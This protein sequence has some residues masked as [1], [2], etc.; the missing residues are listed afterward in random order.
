MFTNFTNIQ[1]Q[2]CPLEFI[3]S[4]ILLPII[5]HNTDRQPYKLIRL[6]LHHKQHNCDQDLMRY[7]LSWAYKKLKTMNSDLWHVTLKQNTCMTFPTRSNIHVCIKLDQDF[8]KTCPSIV[9]AKF[10]KCTTLACKNFVT[11]LLSSCCT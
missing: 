9:Y 7:V 6:F 11:L 4:F 3:Q 5:N 8:M 2:T 10:Y 1:L